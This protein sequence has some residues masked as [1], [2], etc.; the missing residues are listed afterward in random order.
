MKEY[1]NKGHASKLS[2]EESKQ[3][4][5]NTNHIPHHGLRNT[6][7]LRKGRVV[8]KSGAKFQSNSLYENLPKRPSLLNNLIGALI[9][10]RREEFALR[11][12]IAQMFHHIRIS[13]DD[14]DVLHFLWREHI[15]DPVEDFEMNDHFFGK[16]DSPCVANW[17][18]QKTVRDNKDK[19]SFY[20]Y[21]TILENFYM[22]DYLH[23]FPTAQ[24]AINICTEVI[25][26][27][28][29]KDG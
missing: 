27:L 3:I 25:K 5:S 9:K 17:T 22:D 26:S 15:I 18:L 2:L 7:K 20:S 12:D 19:I 21:R 10:F 4:Q 29:I 24:K 23:L 13:Y 14:R 11:G 16:I 8:F 28:R 1:I 6:N